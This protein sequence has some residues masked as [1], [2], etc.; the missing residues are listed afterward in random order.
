MAVLNFAA[1]ILPGKL[2]QWQAFHDEFKL[3][4]PRRKEWEAQ[5]KRAGI[6][7][8][9]VSLQKTPMGEFTVVF[10]EGPDP[11]AVMKNMATSSDPFDKWFALQIKEIHGIDVK[12]P[13]PGPISQFMMDYKA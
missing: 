5:M 7:R 8:Q 12:N 6:T 10:F 9:V 4:G 11:A 3:G 13:A 2:K 1:P